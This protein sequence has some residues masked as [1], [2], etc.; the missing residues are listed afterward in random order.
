[1]RKGKGG[2]SGAAAGASEDGR[3]VR[4]VVD[5]LFF[6]SPG[7]SAGRLKASDGQSIPF[8]GALMVQ[9]SSAVILRGAW[10][11]DPKYGRQFAVESFEFDS[12]LSTDGLAHF[13]ATNPRLPGVGPVKARRI[14]EAFGADFERVLLDPDNG[15]LR[16][17]KVAGLSPADA[18]TLRE[19]W[20]RT[21]ATNATMAWLGQFGLTAHQAQTMV[22]RFGASART[23]LEADPYLLVRELKGF[24]FR[25]VDQIALKIGT[26]KLI[27]P[28][29][30]AGIRAVLVDALEQGD[31]WQDY[32]QLLDA[33]TEL[34]VL[35]V[36]DARERVDAHLDAAVKEGA[37][38][39]EDLGGRVLVALPQIH[40]KEVALA[41]IFG[42]GPRRHPCRERL[43]GAVE[44]LQ[45]M[46]PELNEDQRRA[47]AMALRHGLALISGGAGSGKTFTVSALVRLLEERGLTVTL[48]APTGKAAKRMEEMLPGHSALTLHRLLGYTGGAW[49]Y[50]PGGLD[51]GDVL[52][53]DEVSMV[54]V[55]LAWHLFQ[56]VDLD[57]TAVVLVGDHNQLPPV[58]PGNLLRDLIDRRPF[59][60]AVLRQ[61]MRQAGALKENSTAILQGVVARS[62]PWTEPTEERPWTRSPWLVRNSFTV[63]ADAVEFIRDLFAT[64]LSERCGFD[65][66]SEV[67]LLTPQRKGPLGVEAL[68]LELQRLLQKKLHGVDVPPLAP[69]R[70]T[71]DILLHDRVIQCRNNYDLGV[72]NG[73]IGRVVSAGP[74]RGD[75]VV[76]FDDRE[77][78]YDAEE[79]HAK[80]LALAYALTIHKSQGS[81]F[82]CVVLVVHKAHSY[83]HHRN[84]FYTGVTRA[85][86]SCIIV[87][88]DWGIRNC[89]QKVE[90]SRRKTWLSVLDMSA[91]AG[92]GTEA[93]DESAGEGS[94]AS[95]LSSTASAATALS[96][97]DEVRA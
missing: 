75:L 17:A 47:C 62:S 48:A 38:V 54:D 46:A 93:E 41:R 69:N 51:C 52:V 3:E 53:V 92:Q 1:M 49:Q 2:G 36:P 79:G 72:F 60:A 87:G 94:G 18:L 12:A 65:L 5:R 90:T 84:L 86:R 27:S 63:D 67:Q 31:C 89:A 45:A 40:D 97:L 30:H 58:G 77:V 85:R 9:E 71:P 16:I 37:L 55:P 80:D 24:G 20:E 83:M 88:D 25:R 10:K 6:S 29:I 44:Q 95:L 61:V 34:L 42:R 11:M 39:A 19:E 91:E 8:A 73:S 81:E 76:K 74:R 56:A 64:K 21:K 50:T 32:Q 43:A 14:A 59:P 13:L 26:S 28:R 82:P 78:Q 57:Q 96:T 4:G 68:N 66:L 22:D 33:A 15:H 35:D 70:K 7:W 23:I